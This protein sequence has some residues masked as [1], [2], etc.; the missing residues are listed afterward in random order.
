M[1]E[2]YYLY[3]FWYKRTQQL[4]DTLTS[5]SRNDKKGALYFYLFNKICSSSDGA[6][7]QILGIYCFKIIT[8]RPN[9]VLFYFSNSN[10]LMKKYSEQLG[11]EFYFKKDGTSKLKYDYLQFKQYLTKNIIFNN[12]KMRNTFSLLFKQIKAEMEKME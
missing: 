3:L 9:Y 11:Y 12:Q 6:L 10:N 5:Y 1:P 8:K 4:L 7:S 2:I